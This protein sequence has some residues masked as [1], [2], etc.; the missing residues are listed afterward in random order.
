MGCADPAFTGTTTSSRMQ[1]LRMHF[2]VVE[3]V[4]I[5]IFEGLVGGVRS[6][7]CGSKR[8]SRKKKGKRRGGENELILE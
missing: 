1:T 5:L 2:V 7:A 8:R 4:V 3:D 6:E